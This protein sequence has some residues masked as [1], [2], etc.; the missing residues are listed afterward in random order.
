MAC[1][2]FSRA[3]W[4]GRNVEAH[5]SKLAQYCFKPQAD[6]ACHVF[7]EDPS[8]PNLSDDARDVWP[9]VAVVVGA[10]AL[11]RAAERLA[12]VSGCDGVDN[13]APRSPVEGCDIIPDRGGRE[14]SGT[15]GGVERPLRVVL[16]LDKASCFKS[17]LCELQPEVKPACTRT[18]RKP[19]AG[20]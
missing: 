11:S 5:F 6:M 16:P 10:L 1:A 13:P 7:E 17:R 19:D 18:Q 14:V 12:G 4:L 2:N 9:E 8:R 3:E 20:A 15:L